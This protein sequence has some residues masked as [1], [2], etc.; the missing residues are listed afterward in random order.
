MSIADQPSSSPSPNDSPRS[1]PSEVGSHGQPTGEVP[2]DGDILIPF[3]KV[4]PGVEKRPLLPEHRRKLAASGISDKL[5]QSCGYHSEV[6]GAALGRLGFGRDQRLVP[7]L[8]IPIWGLGGRTNLHQIRP[9]RPRILKG[10]AL[11]YEVPVA[12]KLL[13]DVPPDVRDKVL[14]PSARLLIV[15]G[16]FKADAA[17]SMGLACVATLGVNGW[18]GDVK[19][20]DAIPLDGRAVFIA[21][22]SDVRVNKHV[23][24]AANKLASFLKDRGA[25]VEFLVLPEDADGSKVGLDDFLVTSKSV[26]ALFALAAAELPALPP[27]AEDEPAVMTR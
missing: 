23:H 19:T 6:S 12:T 24:R 13:L 8:L 3:S 17:A 14:D 9:N 1:D 27:S 21:F 25:R 2:S 4:V 7:A 20:W 16:V 5:I 26:D 15:E 22:D 10:R 11:K 18:E